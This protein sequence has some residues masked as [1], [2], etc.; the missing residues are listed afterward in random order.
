MSMALLF[1]HNKSPIIYIVSRRVHIF[2]QREANISLWEFAQGSQTLFSTVYFCFCLGVKTNIIFQMWSYT[3]LE[4]RYKITAAISSISL[5]CTLKE[6]L[7]W[8]D[9]H[10]SKY[11]STFIDYYWVWAS[12]IHIYKSTWDHISK[13][14]S[15]SY[16]RS[17]NAHQNYQKLLT[18]I[19]TRRNNPKK[20][21][22]KLL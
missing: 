16:D 10:A 11:V 19:S 7:V 12:W 14:C 4:S 17:S 3:N 18:P 8:P 2:F 5:N 21:P 20:N 6:N 15:F 13:Q 1:G 22:F 9:I